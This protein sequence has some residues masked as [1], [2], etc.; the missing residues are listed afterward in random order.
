MGFSGAGRAERDDVFF[1]FYSLTAR[2]FQHH[3]LV[4]AG[5]GFKVKAIE[6]FDGWELRGFDPALDHAPF[7]VDQF[8]LGQ[9]RQVAH[10]I[11]TFRGTDARLLV[12]LTQESGQAQGLKM[13]GK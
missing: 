12:V 4:E 10:M 2:Q 6:A 3:H 9:P 13:M 11:H 5:N 8:Q 7:S 1:A